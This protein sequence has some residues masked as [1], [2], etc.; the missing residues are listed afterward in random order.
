MARLL[1]WVL[2][3]VL[4]W[5]AAQVLGRIPVGPFLA[6]TPA[7]TAFGR[8][9]SVALLLTGVLGI[10]TVLSLSYG[11]WLLIAAI[12]VAAVVAIGCGIAFV[13]L[14]WPA[15]LG[16]SLVGMGL[17]FAWL[18][19]VSPWAVRIDAQSAQAPIL[20]VGGFGLVALAFASTVV[21]IEAL[22]ALKPPEQP[23]GHPRD[24]GSQPLSPPKR[25]R[26]FGKSRR[27]R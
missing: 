14:W 11:T 19:H 20:I 26:R 16:G 22:Q 13:T 10:A 2:A 27:G 24:G 25:R 12:V 8:S 5:T 17:G 9:V 15:A 7:R 3:P 18:P 23:V 6:L 1:L 21:T 4:A